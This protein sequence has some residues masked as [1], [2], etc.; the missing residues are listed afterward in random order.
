MFER[1]LAKGTS[2]FS[3]L[4]FTALVLFMTPACDSS[5]PMEPNR[6]PTGVAVL[7]A[8]PSVGA[9]GTVFAITGLDL[10]PAQMAGLTLRLA[11]QPGTVSL[12][13]TGQLLGAVPFLAA[14]VDG[15]TAPVAA[16]DFELLVDG[17]IVGLG[18]AAFTVQALVPAPGSSAA[19]ASAFTTLGRELARVGDYLVTEP[20]VE[21]QWIQATVGALDELINGDDPRS[22]ASALTELAGES[23]ATLELLDAFVAGSGILAR[24]EALLAGMQ[25]VTPATKN[26]ASETEDVVLA[27]KMQF[28]VLAK[29][30]G[31]TVIHET[32]ETYSYT[33]GLATGL[34]GIGYNLPPAVAVIS[35]V[36]AVAD[37]AVNK[38][39]LGVLPATITDF[40]LTLASVDLAFGETTDAALSLTAV[41]AP[42]TTGILDFI[43]L[44]FAAMGLV[45]NTA[46]FQNFGQV[47]INANS[48]Y[49]SLLQQL[50]SSY[51]E[52]HPE[53]TLDVSF[54]LVPALTWTT[55]IHDP[56]LAKCLSVAPDLVAGLED[57]IN[58]QAGS[59][60]AG[61]TEIYART[62]LGPDA[63]LLYLPPG[64]TYSGGAFGEE[65][66]QT[67]ATTVHVGGDLVLTLDFVESLAVG[68]FEP[69]TVWATYAVPG[70][71]P[72]IATGIQIDLL[73]DGGTV[74]PV[75][76]VTNG[77]GKFISTASLAAGSTGL[78]ITVTATDATGQQAT[79]SVT[80]A[81]VDGSSLKSLRVHGSAWADATL[82]GPTG[83]S[84]QLSDVFADS[85]SGPDPIYAGLEDYDV[86]AQ[87]SGFGDNYAEGIGR[88]HALGQA[89]QEDNALVIW[90]RASASGYASYRLN[91]TDLYP[92]LR[93]GGGGT[94]RFVAR[95]AVAGGNSVQLSLEHSTVNYG[96]QGES[97][98]ATLRR[99][100]DGA[101][102]ALIQLDGTWNG[103]LSEAGVYEVE[104]WAQTS[105]AWISQGS[106]PSASVAVGN[107]F[108][109]M[110]CTI[111]L[112]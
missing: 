63:L 95:F 94:A 23:P 89:T 14:G 19:L 32:V 112:P 96:N 62:G 109:T 45:P 107:I 78:V 17:E 73:V 86:H 111:S 33:V 93:A 2:N 108:G 24:T 90:G 68:G 84:V 39:L 26:A 53:L 71:E 91:R 13:P 98:A 44:M 47:L 75:S 97:L 43:N 79:E 99:L 55:T 103:T 21:E 50:L 35:A 102:L 4:I 51:A 88:A 70:G 3:R 15:L 7:T 64:F 34:I 104:I 58:W 1:L 37:F 41:N 110:S 40:S 66:K 18:K 106:A 22:L 25:A 74:S 54:S 6:P 38:V 28:Y 87:F 8:F 72:I 92:E 46:S 100:A 77:A 57:A 11:G 36:L 61:S 101:E 69:L 10:P 48:F 42:P 80:A 31:E 65:V 12:S 20:G 59:S 76:G 49:T 29:L 82:T 30:F 83:G 5:D 16:Q 60:Q 52:S 56:R 9:P 81:A 67:A 105:D 85:S 27:R